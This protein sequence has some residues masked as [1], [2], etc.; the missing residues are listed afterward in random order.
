MPA[1]LE[2]IAREEFMPL[3]PTPTL[4]PNRFRILKKAEPRVG[5]AAE[6]LVGA[7]LPQRPLK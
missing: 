3:Q 7:G 5:A 6:P 1:E 4:D 2:N